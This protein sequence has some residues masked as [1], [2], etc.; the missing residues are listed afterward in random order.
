METEHVRVDQLQTE[1]IELRDQLAK[2]KLGNRPD[3]S[4]KKISFIGLL[5]LD[6]DVR[7]GLIRD[8]MSKFFPTVF[9]KDCTMFTRYDKEQKVHIESNVGVVEFSSQGVRDR[10]F[11]AISKD[12]VKHKF[13]IG[14]KEII[15]KK[16]RSKSATLRNLALREACDAAKKR[17]GEAEA[18]NVEIKWGPRHVEYKGEIVFKQPSGHDLG[19]YIGSFEGFTP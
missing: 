6:F 8:Y 16:T 9:L 10:V 11:D 15:V 2:L 17:V 5:K 7:V 3:D 13:T 14:N 12:P 1:V 4:F 18:G 19:S